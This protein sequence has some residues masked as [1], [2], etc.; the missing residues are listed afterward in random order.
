[1]CGRTALS[2]QPDEIQ[3]STNYEWVPDT[4]KS[5]YRPSHNV[6]PTMTLPIVTK[7]DGKPTITL[8]RWGFNLSHAHLING[9][10]DSFLARKYPYSQVHRN[11]AIFI[12]EG[13]YEWKTEGKSKQP[14]YFKLNHGL[15]LMA[16]LWRNDKELGRTVIVL[17]TEASPFVAGVHHR[18][19]AILTGD[20]VNQWL[21]PDTPQSIIEGLL[22]PNPVALVSFPVGQHVNNVKCNGPECIEPVTL[23]KPAKSIS[24]FFTKSPPKKVK[25]ESWE[26]SSGVE[27]EHPAK[28]A[29]TPIK[30]E[31]PEV[32][33]VKSPS[34]V[35]K[36]AAPSKQSTLKFGK[37]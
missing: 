25:D 10:N 7:T 37:S 29:I 20:Q 16:A 6:K 28:E 19:P 34:R 3:R 35:T 4:D 32:S 30:E 17:T 15:M 13:F 11:R 5:Q 27:V 12:A 2:L 36:K 22:K 33:K 23:A 21:D 24:S 31:K 18:M 8:A 9:R 1:M 26:S 14:Y